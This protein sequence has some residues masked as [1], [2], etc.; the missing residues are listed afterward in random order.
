MNV[1]KIR[2]YDYK[3]KFRIY[4]FLSF[5]GQKKLKPFCCRRFLCLR[6]SL[7]GY[8]RVPAAKFRYLLCLIFPLLLKAEFRIAVLRTSNTH[9]SNANLR[10]QKLNFVLLKNI[11]IYLFI[12]IYVYL[13]YVHYF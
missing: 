9:I 1:A 12:Y 6:T 4:F 8:M 11:F 2:F 7:H 13:I 5:E 10:Q 3:L